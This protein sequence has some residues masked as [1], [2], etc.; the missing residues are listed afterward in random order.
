M[1]KDKEKL[2]VLSTHDEKFSSEELV[3]NPES[4]GWIK[5]GDILEIF[6][7]DKPHKSIILRVN[8]LN[9]VK[10]NKQERNLINLKEVFKLV[11][12]NSLLLTLS[13]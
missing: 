5:V 11:W 4:F 12:I 9:P 2:Y 8:Q 1:S 6:H 3:I 13:F 7:P 10:G